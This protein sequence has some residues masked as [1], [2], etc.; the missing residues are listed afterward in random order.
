MK[1]PVIAVYYFN[2]AYAYEEENEKH[3]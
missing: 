3:F 2:S 1:T